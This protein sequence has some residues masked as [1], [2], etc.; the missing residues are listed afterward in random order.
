ME[1]REGVA[2]AWTVLQTVASAARSTGQK[3]QLETGA[4]FYFVDP[5]EERFF[6][7]GNGSQVSPAAG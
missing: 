5:G 6:E 2:Y 3:R 4:V 7:S 1:S